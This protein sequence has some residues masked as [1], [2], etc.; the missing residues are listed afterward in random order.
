MQ[1][2]IKLPLLYPTTV[3]IHIS[4]NITDYKYGYFDDPSSFEEQPYMQ[5][6]MIINGTGKDKE[7]NESK[8]QA[9]VPAIKKS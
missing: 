2:L 8:Y 6:V 3:D 5:P 7:G 1:N 9:M 4:V